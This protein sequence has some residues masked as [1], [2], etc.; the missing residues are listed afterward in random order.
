[1]GY[2]INVLICYAL[3]VKERILR[4]SGAMLTRSVLL[5]AVDTSGLAWR[6]NGNLSTIKIHYADQMQ[7]LQT[8]MSFSFL[9]LPLAAQTSFHLHSSARTSKLLSSP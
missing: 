6:V 2:C 3:V 7:N 4:G 9:D 5:V 1:M 8:A